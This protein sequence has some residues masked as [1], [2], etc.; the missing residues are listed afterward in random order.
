MR[1]LQVTNKIVRSFKAMGCGGQEIFVLKDLA[2]VVV[3]TGANYVSAVPCD[4][5][6]QRYI[7]PAAG[8]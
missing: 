5:I 4:E 8:M 3:F 6:V 7:L 1:I 2:M